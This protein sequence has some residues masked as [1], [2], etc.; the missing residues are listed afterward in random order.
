[1]RLEFL[2][3]L[4]AS[5]FLTSCGPLFFNHIRPSSAWH[6]QDMEEFLEKNYPNGSDE[7]VLIEYFQSHYYKYEEAKC[8]APVCARTLSVPAHCSWFWGGEAGVVIGWVPDG[9][10]KITRLW[11]N[12]TMCMLGP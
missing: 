12:P 9:E 4:L 3:L 1:M 6:A 2:A 10:G 5:F 8:S 7:K 11:T